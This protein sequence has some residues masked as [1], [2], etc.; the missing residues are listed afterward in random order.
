MASQLYSRGYEK[1]AHLYD[2]FDQKKNIEFFHHYASAA[3]DV[4][5]I[6]AG[7]G[8]IAMPLAKRGVNLWCVEPSTAMRRE[9]KRKLVRWPEL[10]GQITIVAGDACTF[11][12]GRTFPTA[13]MSGSF[14]HLVDDTQRRKALTNIGDHLDPGGVLVFD[15]FLGLMHDSPPCP[16]G[17]V[18]LGDRE[19]RRYVGGQ[20]LPSGQKEVTLIFEI[21]QGGQF[22]ERIEE[23]GRVGITSRAD[24]HRVLAETGFEVRHEW[25]D[26][27]CTPYE[28]DESLLIVEATRPH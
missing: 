17:A 27:D 9:F 10:A 4:L 28:E 6:G 15:V 19:I 1:T 18:T 25:S 23:Q 7:T 20:I 22:V 13:L 8:R 2:L 14:D 24:V 3:G 16:A 5:D 12:F 26:Y 21:W 11:H